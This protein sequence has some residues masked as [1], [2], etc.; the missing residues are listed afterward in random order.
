M[1]LKNTAAL[2]LSAVLALGLTACGSAASPAVDSTVP[3]GD[4]DPTT[5]TVAMECAY[6]PYNWTQNDDTNGAVQIRDS[7]DYAYGY[8]VIMAKKIGEALGQNVQIVKLDWDSLIPA[9]T[10]GDVDCVIAGQSI[11]AERAAQVDFSDPYYYASIVTLVKK[12]SKYADAKSVAD[13]DGATA[14]SQLGTIWYDNCLPQ[15][16]NGNIL[17]AQETAPAMLVA[18]NSGACDV[19]VTDRPTAQAALVAYPDFTLLDFG[20]G[21]NDFQ[22]SQEDIN[23]GISMKKGNTALRDAINEVLSGMTADDYNDLM[24]EAIAAQPLSE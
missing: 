9:V 21:E 11:T 5:L 8:D 17:A 10:S 24:D 2:A 15:I 7:G 6:A 23:I 20:G 12:D 19:V 22:V 1:K 13:L 14:T 3:D 18:L 16:P 4:G